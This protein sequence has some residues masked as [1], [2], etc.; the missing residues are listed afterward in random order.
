MSSATNRLDKPSQAQQPCPADSG[1]ATHTP[2]APEGARRA[3][4]GNSRVALPQAI[5]KYRVVER[6]GVGAMG[7]VYKCTQPGLDRP[8]A[9]KVLLAARHAGEAEVQ[10]FQ[11]EARAAARLSHPNVVQ[12]HDFGTEAGLPFLV[13]EYV[14]GCSLARLIGTPLLSV[15]TTLRLV[16]QVARAL[17]AAHEQGIIHRDLKPSNILIH[18]SGLPKLADFGLA[19]LLHDTPAPDKPEVGRIGNPSYAP[20]RGLS[21]SGDLIGTPQYMSPEQVL[22]TPQDIDARTDVYSLGAVMYE[23]LT[24]RPPVDGPNVLAILRKLSDEEPIPLRQLNEAVP[25]GV[26]AICRQAMAKDREARFPSAGCFAEAIQ[27]YLVERLLRRPEPLTLPPALDLPPSPRPALPPPRR[28]SGGPRWPVVLAL[29]AVVAALALGL[30]ALAGW[31]RRSPEHERAQLIAQV[32][33]PWGDASSPLADAPRDRLK[34]LLKDQAA[35]LQRAPDDV[36]VRLL[37]ARTHRRSGEHLAAIED[38]G[39]VLRRDPD[40]LAARNER[41]LA[42]YQLHVLYLGNCNEPLL[43]T[44][45]PEQLREDL[46]VLLRGPEKARK[47]AA[48]L[49]QALARA[50]YGEAGRIAEGW[51]ASSEPGRG[52]DEWMLAADALS[53]AAEKAFAEETETADEGGKADKK[54]RREELVRYAGDACR[55]GLEADPYHVGLLFLQADSLQRRATWEANANEERTEVLLRRYQPAFEA[56]CDRLRQVTLRKGPDTPVARAILLSNSGRDEA[57]LEQVKDALGC[58]PGFPYAHTLAAWL[59]LRTRPDASLPVEEAGRLLLDLQP[60]F[61]PLPEDFNSFFVRALVQAAAGRWEEAR[62]DLRSCRRRLG[63]DDLP[64]SVPAYNDWLGRANA[65]TTEYLD[66]TLALLW[67]LPVPADSR[68][69][70]A[71]QI[72]K[73]LDDSKAVAKESLKPERVQTLLAQA[74]VSLAR[75]W[76]G[77]PEGKARVRQHLEK[78]LKQQAPGVTVAALRADGAFSAWNEDPDFVTLYQQFDKP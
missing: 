28:R 20:A 70:L 33:A 16:Y 56:A 59:H 62:A 19:K 74:H 6:L 5:G 52:P 30:G 50:D 54:R 9:V 2:G 55:R 40:N 12:V 23:M 58:R 60:G 1:G 49:I 73:R 14:D 18:K 39:H 7:V 57:A 43:R 11:R 72:V 64:T 32:E 17:Q 25:E 15:E 53:H 51:V 21:N 13:M 46:Q 3:L 10:R 34:A 67:Q 75:A 42:V 61:E 8:V 78:A 26:A 29:A 45:F 47:P 44:P 69:G 37:R 31:L 65:G 71:E 77:K 4:V 36:E 27:T 35:F 68:I 24:G 48:H 76:A 63:R 66:A 22:A 41:A 38:A